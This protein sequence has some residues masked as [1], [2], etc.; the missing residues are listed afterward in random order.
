VLNSIDAKGK[1]QSQS[2]GFTNSKVFG[3]IADFLKKDALRNPEMKDVNL[4]FRV[5]DCRIYIDPFDTKISDFKMKL[6]GDMGLDQTLNFKAKMSIP[7]AQLGGLNNLADDLLSKAASKGL[8][9]KVS[10]VINLNVKIGGTTTNPEVRPDWGGG[11]S[12]DSQT[13]AKET[14]KETVKAKTKEE[15]LKLIADAEKEA[16]RLHDEAV[17]TGDKLRAEA[18]DKADKLVAEGNKKGGLAAIAAKK[19]AD[20]LKKEADKAAKKLVKEADAKGQ[21]LID[22]AKLEAAK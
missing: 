5:K 1:L 11:E 16:A 12:D 9:V 2:I 15:A 22:K 21:A 20:E 17:A 10:D 13:S 18:K 3:K 7:R 19:A 14:V 8:N 6:G 4:S